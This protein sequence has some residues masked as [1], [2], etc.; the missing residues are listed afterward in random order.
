MDV[1]AAEMREKACD[2]GAENGSIECELG[3]FVSCER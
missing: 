2:L 1:M 3:V